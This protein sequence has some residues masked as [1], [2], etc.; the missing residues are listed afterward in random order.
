M[1]FDQIFATPR[2]RNRMDAGRQLAEQ[3]S[4]YQERSDVV[5]LGLPRGGVPVAYE[6]A[7]ALRVP[8]D[9]FVVRK[10]G[11]PGH[12]EFAIGA[13]ASGGVRVID[14][15]IVAA[16]DVTEE[17]LADV[18]SRE[19]REL[20]RR[21]QR[22]RGTRP[23]MPL[24]GKTVILVDDGLATGATMR[25]AVQALHKESPARLVVAVP[26]A[27]MDT[28]ELLRSMADEVIC[29]V[30]P[31]PFYAVGLWYHDFSQTTDTEVHDLLQQ[32]GVD[33]RVEEPWRDIRS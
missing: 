19:L 11:M 32:G 31:E 6:V 1:E 7:R 9:V 23:L 18:T 12:E 14:R 27:A 21:E 4:A 5:V 26:V 17:Q 20:R 8:L 33:R 24:R 16:Y 2:F 22:Y 28:C 3:L 15:D 30:T 29:L 10:L 25:A 13:I